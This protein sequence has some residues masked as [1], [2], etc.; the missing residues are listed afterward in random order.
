MPNSRQHSKSIFRA[1]TRFALLLMCTLALLGTAAEPQTFTVLHSFAGGADGAYPIAG[2]TMA[3]SENFYGTTQEGGNPGVGVVYRLAHVGGRWIVTPIYT[4]LGGY[5][6]A[7]PY[8]RVIVGLNNTLFGTTLNG[9]YYGQGTVFNLIPPAAACSAVACGLMNT[10]IYRFLGGNDGGVPQYGDLIFDQ[11][12]NIYGT[13]TG[14]TGPG[15]VYELTPVN[16][17]WTESIL[18]RFDSENTGVSPEGGVI[19]D[20]AGNLYGTTSSGGAYGQ[21]TV[22]R[23]SPSGSG[24]AETILYSFQGSSDGAYPTGGLV[25]DQSGNLY[26][27][28]SG[29]FHSPGSVFELSPSQGGW[30][31]R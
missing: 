8:A 13:T 18:Y 5:Y 12:G 3:G 29:G 25:L 22:F 26:G 14:L 10:V 11:Q 15:T 28:A 16:G 4:F 19:F 27:T 24:W 17:G 1:K 6:G 21:G 23:L 7:F 9:G 31:L 2:L 20:Q 30:T